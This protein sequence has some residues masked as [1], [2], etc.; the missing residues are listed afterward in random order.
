MSFSPF[1]TLKI[2]LC[3]ILAVAAVNGA[4]DVKTTEK[5]G[6]YSG[7]GYGYSG[8]GY[9]GL[10]HGG[11]YGGALSHGAGYYGGLGGLGG[12]HG[13]YYGGYPGSCTK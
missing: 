12:Y 1:Q 5:R 7:L 8:L 10:S 9:G 11:Y 13:G 3:L 2:A 6:I 4:D